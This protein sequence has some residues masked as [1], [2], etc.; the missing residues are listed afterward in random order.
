MDVKLDERRVADALEAVHL[1]GLDHEDVTGPSFEL[2]AIH[3]VTSAS[4]TDELH[5]VIWMTVRPWSSP[6]PAVE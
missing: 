1:A 2:L 4:F 5:F 6:W 3:C